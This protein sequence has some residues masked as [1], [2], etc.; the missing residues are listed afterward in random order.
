MQ[1]ERI[2]VQMNHF[3]WVQISTKSYSSKEEKPSVTKVVSGCKSTISESPK[4]SNFHGDRDSV[5]VELKIIYERNQLIFDKTYCT[6][7]D[8]KQ[9]LYRITHC[10][11]NTMHN[12]FQMSSHVKLYKA[13]YYR[14]K[15]K[16]SIM[17]ASV[18]D[19][20]LNTLEVN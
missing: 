16:L 6:T 3:R 9:M 8:G 18:N 7:Y 10:E 14:T 12:V 1:I 11:Y 4:K 19:I 15:S 20:N 5:V 17:T 2:S 13:V